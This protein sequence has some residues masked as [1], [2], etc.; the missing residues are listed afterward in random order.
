VPGDLSLSR[1]GDLAEAAGNL[2][3]TLH[4]ADALAARRGLD[5]IDVAPIPSVGLGRAILDRLR[6]ASAA[7]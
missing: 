3:E 6:R 2:F 5:R 4:R 7:R 1:S